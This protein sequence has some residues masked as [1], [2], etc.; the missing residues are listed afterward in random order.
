M[1]PQ[2]VYFVSPAVDVLAMGG[3]SLAL[4]PVLVLAPLSSATVGAAVMALWW[5]GN[6]PHFS[7]T[8]QRLYGAREH[9]R[10]FPLTAWLLPPL[11]LAV[12]LAV[13]AWP[14]LLAGPFV[15]L[16]VIWSVY[17]FSGQ[18]L[19]LT[20]IYAR[21]AGLSISPAARRALRLFLLGVFV[22]RVASD[23]AG[24]GERV[25]LGIAHS[26]LGLP[27]W[28][29]PVLL[30][31]AILAGA[32]FLADSWRA[33]ARSGRPL[34]II[35]LLPAASFLVWFMPGQRAPYFFAFVPLFHSVQYLLV[36]WAVQLKGRLETRKV[37]PSGSFVRR[38]SLRWALVNFVGGAL[39]FFA[40]PKLGTI[41]GASPTFSFAIVASAVQLHHFFV[42]GVIWKIRQPAVMSPLLV[43]IDDLIKPA[44]E[45]PRAAATPTRSAAAVA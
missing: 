19:G 16:V 8:L 34:P 9:V 20:L 43:S 39:L 42:D 3:L 2:S 30:L 38:E 35:V 31:P 14:A 28:L 37:A 1:R 24:T 4:Y 13:F 41:G 25:Y 6:W 33:R 29:G 40:L 26:R 18:T 27:E 21:R 44:H 36:A 22:A 23:E 15:A 17:H 32:L 45:A 10:Q 11:V 12:T 7:A 5:V